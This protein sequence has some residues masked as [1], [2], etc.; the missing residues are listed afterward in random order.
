MA[1]ILII[2]DDPQVCSLLKQVFEDEGYT[3]QSALNG[4][5]GINRYRDKPAEL[6]ILD[7]LMPE[8]EGL[9]TIVD[10]RREFPHVKI[11][12]M[13]AG[14]ERAKINLLDLARRLGAQHTIT[15]PF[16][17]LAI[18]D[19]VAK[20]LKNG[21]KTIPDEEGGDALFSDQT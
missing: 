15:K 3:V 16:D 14:S 1:Y 10:L 20:L 4:V 5:E 7:I 12:A 13:S 11:I 19:L 17:L 2:D 9:E 8:K 21:G 6:V 18:T